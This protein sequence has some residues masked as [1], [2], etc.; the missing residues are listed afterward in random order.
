V[1]SDLPAKKHPYHHFTDVLGNLRL[2][3]PTKEGE[4]PSTKLDGKR[5]AE[6]LEKNFDHL[7]PNDDGVTREEL[8]QALLARNSYSEEEYA[9]LQL[10]G[11]YFD[12]IANMA[13][14]EKGPQ[15]V[16][17]RMDKDVLNQFLLYGNLNLEELH[18]WRAEA[19]EKHDDK[20]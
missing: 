12:T 2:T 18:K 7:D 17:T 9:M 20:P 1:T 3:G 10:L 11:Y 13:D 6:L 8:A 15:T 5:L 4:P 14:D 19:L 16:I